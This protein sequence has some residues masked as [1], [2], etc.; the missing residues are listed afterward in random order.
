MHMGGSAQNTEAQAG[1]AVGEGQAA[2]VVVEAPV[3]ANQPSPVVIGDKIFSSTQEAIAYA[4]GL[5]SSPTVQSNVPQK[6]V[7]PEDVLFEEPASA[8]AM[9]KEEIK[10]EIRGESQIQQNN[11]KVWTD[12][13]KNYPDLSGNE[14]IVELVRSQLSEDVRDKLPLSQS[15]PILAKQARDRLAKIRGSSAN[16]GIQLPSGPAITAGSSGASP[17]PVS[18]PKAIPMNFIEELK[19]SRQRK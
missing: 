5:A 7:R 15:I 1:Q 12:F 10:N 4:N 6:R 18:M 2:P 17:P 13:Y 14:D 9:L 11:N 3:M 19:A 16:Q 8:F